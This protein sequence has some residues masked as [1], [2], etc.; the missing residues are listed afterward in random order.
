VDP[1]AALAGEALLKRLLAQRELFGRL[2]RFEAVTASTDQVDVDAFTESEGLAVSADRRG[3]SGVQER[4]V[5]ANLL[6]REDRG[7]AN[8]ERQ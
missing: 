8:D 5:L 3:R 4:S 6:L 2:R 7:H 1:A